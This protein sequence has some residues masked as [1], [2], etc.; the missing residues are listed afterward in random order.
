MQ[1]TIFAS[2]QLRDGGEGSY[3]GNEF[4]SARSQNQG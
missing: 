2:G 1:A 4:A 3:S